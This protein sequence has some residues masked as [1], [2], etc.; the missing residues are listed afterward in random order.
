MGQL[1]FL[2]YYRVALA[3][4]CGKRMAASP[5]LVAM[6]AFPC[7]PITGRGEGTLAAAACRQ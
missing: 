6:P 4:N 3:G 1:F 5:P 7:D 2:P